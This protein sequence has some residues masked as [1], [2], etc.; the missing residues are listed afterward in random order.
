MEPHREIPPR[1]TDVVSSAMGRLRSSWWWGAL[2]FAGIVATHAVTY[3]V[4]EHDHGARAALLHDTGHRFWPWVATVGIAAAV[5]AL[6]AFVVRSARPDQGPRVGLW[7]LAALQ[8]GGWLALE[9]FDRMAFGHGSYDSLFDAPMLVGLLVQVAVAA[10]GALLL[11]ALGRVIGFIRAARRRPR[12][13][14]A[15]PR[16]SPPT[17]GGCWPSLSPAV[18]R[19]PPLR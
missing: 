2:A 8:G 10:V 7:S 6:V 15:N 5:A 18:P 17:R 19:G 13:A 3:R 9:G 11:A 1:K 12:R 16:P 14:G 4:V